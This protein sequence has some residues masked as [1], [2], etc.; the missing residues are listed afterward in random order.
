MLKT[1][2][3]PFSAGF[4]FLIKLRGVHEVVAE[5]IRMGDPVSFRL[6]SLPNQA[7]RLDEGKQGCQ[8]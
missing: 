6:C 4:G 1:V 8:G 2:C 7:A 3:A 5:C